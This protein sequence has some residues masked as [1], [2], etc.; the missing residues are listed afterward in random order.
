M[1]MLDTI[2]FY[3]KSKLMLNERIINA[4]IPPIILSYK[5]CMNV[6]ILL[7]LY[8]SFYISIQTRIICSLLF[9]FS[10]P[11]WIHVIIMM[12]YKIFKADTK[13]VSL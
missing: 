8:V 13:T 3:L 5:Y 4:N 12:S 6:S 9:R 2:F 10:E 1:T 11:L 7:F